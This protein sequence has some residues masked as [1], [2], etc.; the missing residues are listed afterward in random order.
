MYRICTTTSMPKCVD[1]IMD[2]S[3]PTK[4]TYHAQ[5]HFSRAPVVLRQW[6]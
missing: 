4:N 5:K 6:L 1:E 2:K 3:K